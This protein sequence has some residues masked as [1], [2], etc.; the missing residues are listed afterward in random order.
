MKE[1]KETEYTE[2][3][4]EDAMREAFEIFV[5]MHAYFEVLDTTSGIIGHLDRWSNNKFYNASAYFQ[6]DGAKYA[7]E[8]AE[9]AGK[10]TTTYYRFDNLAE[11]AAFAA[12]LLTEVEE[13]V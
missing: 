13:G 6:H 10:L 1:I 2:A 4:S 3:Y 5:Q 11:A 9:E 12:K 8:R 7:F